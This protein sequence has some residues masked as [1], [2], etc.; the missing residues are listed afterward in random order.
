MTLNEITYSILGQVRPVLTMD[1]NLTPLHVKNDIIAER[2]NMIK[3]HLENGKL[4]DEVFIQDLGCIPLEVVDAAECCDITTDCTVI[5]TAVELPQEIRFTRVG[6]IDKTSKRFT[7]IPYESV[8]YNGNGKFNKNLIFAFHL[9]NRI[10]LKSN[11]SNIGLLEY[12]NVRGVF[13]DPRLIK[14]FLCADGKPCYSDDE[15]FPMP[16]WMEV[17]IRERLITSY[18]R[19]EQLPKDLNN[20]AKDQKTD[21]A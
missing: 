11:D 20:D 4:V 12:I 13:E 15:S 16:K 2:A 9:N 10:Y 8:N 3:S 14:D 6:P 7:M 21:A 19:S 17:H 1:S 18:L 5:R